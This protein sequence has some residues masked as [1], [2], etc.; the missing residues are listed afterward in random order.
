M[1]KTVL[2]HQI[3]IWMAGDLATAHRVCRDHCYAEGACFTITPSKFVYTG[4]EEDGFAIGLVNYPR[5]PT[6]AKELSS[7]AEKLA[8]KLLASCNQRTC[9]L[10]GTTET[11]WVVV[12]P[13]AS[14]ADCTVCN[15]CGE[16]EVYPWIDQQCPACCGT[17]KV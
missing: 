3:T 7:R 14:R 10:V 5:F 13:P 2:T 16:V 1:T 6:T 15:G 17:G 4:G 8:G 11:R 9:L 12:E